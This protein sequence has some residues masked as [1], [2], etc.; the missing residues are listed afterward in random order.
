M[1]TRRSRTAAVAVGSVVLILGANTVAD[2]ANGHA[3]L[4]GRTG[5]ETHT[6]TIANAHKGAALSLVS[7][8]KVAPL[9]VS[10]STK[11][12]RLNADEVDGLN[13]AQLT[14]RALVASFDQP[15]L[16]N[17]FDA[18]W[19]LKVAPGPYAV[20]FS[21]AIV[22]S[23][24]ATV[25]APIT[26]ACG[27]RADESPLR[28]AQSAQDVGAFSHEVLLSGA[29]TVVATAGDPYISIECKSSSSA[30]FSLEAGSGARLT[31]TPINS[32]TPKPLL[33][34]QP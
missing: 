26:Y 6:T 18:R 29:D 1:S 8:G 21:I 16:V 3:W 14:T 24:S 32:I 5:H 25:G 27:V 22:G 31:A 15:T 20:S 9:K 30:S 19:Y 23:G 7:P 28:G 11:V 12:A 4:L 17:N 2:A 34:P 33:E 10:N 13:G